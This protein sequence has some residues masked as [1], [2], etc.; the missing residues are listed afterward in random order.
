MS[1]ISIPGVSSNS[2]V[3][4][5]KMV[6]EIMK[7]E[8]APV[9]R[10]ENRV[11]SM[12]TERTVWRDMSRR[13][14]ELRDAS[15]TLYGFESPFSER[16]TNS[17]DP[18]S[19][20]ATAGRR[21]K[22]LTSEIEV[23]QVAGRD[24]F[25]SDNLPRDYEVSQG[26]YEFTVGEQSITVR[27]RGGS[28]SEF[29]DRI[30]A[31]A[32]ELVEARVVNNTATTQVFVLESQKTGAENTLSFSGPSEEF[33][34]EAGLIERTRTG[35]REPSLGEEN[36][37]MLRP[38]PVEGQEVRFSEE[39]VAVPPQSQAEI[40]ISE[41]VAETRGM[42]LELS[43]DLRELPEEEAPPPPPGPSVPE[44]GGVS[45][46]EITVQ[47]E[48]SQVELPELEEEEPREPVR[49]NRV[50]QIVAG[51]RTI[52]LPAIEDG[53]SEIQIPLEDVA[54][55]VDAIRLVNRN[56]NRELSI[57]DLRIYDPT[58]RGDA[59][60]KQ[61]IETASDA[62]IRVDGVRT[63]RPSN[64][65]DDIIPGVTLNIHG[66]SA[67][68]VSLE[69]APDREAAKESIIQ[70]VGLYNQVIRDI[71]IYTR[72]Q[73]EIVDE[74][75]YFSDE[76]REQALERLGILQGDSLLNQMQ[77]RMQRIMM[78]PHPTEANEQI[79]LLAQIGISTNAGAVGSREINP[80]R[81]RGY[82]EINEEELDNA[83]QTDFEAVR[84]LFG[85]DSDGDLAADSGA[86]V[87]MGQYL[88]PYVRTGGIVAN[89]TQTLDG[90]VDRAEERINRYDERLEEYEREL[91]TDFARMEGA[92]QQL[93]ENQQAL[94]RL[95]QSSG[96]NNR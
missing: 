86:A 75:E 10:L 68:P 36:V 33:A 24:R 26:A 4:T 11:D 29:A 71:N 21:A 54:G 67:G 91:R 92:M 46:E 61:P 7:A 44:T 12:E 69:V 20:T 14:G 15:R 2:R 53:S 18:G 41:P 6:E 66:Q 59:V 84:E 25:T 74:I 8:R 48:R 73:E 80:S 64:E 34:L 5:D 70:F 87:E 50:L 58:A 47:S 23:L 77:S 16:T 40:G 56:T 79:R 96:G 42:V 3:N 89:R 1:D 19:V 78:D 51:D 30:N 57:S 94:D 31:T 81:M 27:F 13:L 82:L 65:I 55:R 52:D 22:E 28:L 32:G 62:V 63:V 17:S 45:L 88:Q 85:F 76:E 90:Q 35:M 38:S 93:E 49:D 95:Q 72:N 39:G 43:A 9:R 83:L 37:R 60:P